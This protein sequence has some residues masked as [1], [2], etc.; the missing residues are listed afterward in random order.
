MKAALSSLLFLCFFSVLIGNLVYNQ[1]I[2]HIQPDGAKLNLLVSGD[3]YYHRVHD[4]KGY[5]ILQHPETGYVVYAIPDGNS[6]K[7]SDYVV[8]QSDPVALGIHPNLMKNIEESDARYQ[9]QQQYI[10]SETRTPTTGLIHNIVIFL[11]FQDQ[12]E[13]L[14]SPDF[15]WYN[16]LFNSTDQASLKDYYLK[17]SSYE[18]NMPSYFYPQPYNGQYVVSFVLPYNRGYFSPYNE[19]TNP[20]GYADVNDETNRHLA[21][22]DD[23]CDFL[24]WNVPDGIDLDI[25]N[26]GMVDALTLIFR[27]APD[28]WSDFLWPAHVT[29]SYVVGLINTT[30]VNHYVKVIE[31]G[32]DP[33]TLCH[34]TGHMIGFPDLYHYSH[35]EKLP[36]SDWDIMASSEAMHH[37]TYTKW[38]YGGWFSEIPVITPTPTPTQ[39]TL[40]AI[41]QNPYSCYK[42]ESNYPGQFYMLEYRRQIG[43]YEIGVPGTGLIAYRVIDSYA[44]NDVIGNAQGPPDE[45]Y[46]YR[47]EGNISNDGYVGS[48]NFSSTAGRVEIH[49]QTDPQPWIFINPSAQMDGNLVITEIGPSGGN[50]ITFKVSS[51]IPSYWLWDG[52]HDNNWNN[53]ANWSKNTVP[54]YDKDVVIPAGTPFYPVITSGINCN[55]LV[56]KS[57]AS[58]F[59]DTGNLHVSY[60][61]QNFGSLFMNFPNG[62]LDAQ[63]I[64]FYSGSSAQIT[65]PTVEISVWGNLTFHLGSD[66][67]IQEG[68]IIFFGTTNSQLAVNCPT[69][70]KNLRLNK[71]SPYT[72]TCTSSIATTLTLYGNLDIFSGNNLIN[73]MPG[74]LAI[75]G[76]FSNFSSSFT[77]CGGSVR[78]EGNSAAILYSHNAVPITFAALQIAK[79]SGALVTLNASVTCTSNLNISGGGGLAVTNFNLSINADL[80][81]YGILQQTGM[82][83]ITVGGMV[84]WNSGATMSVTNS[85][86][87]LYVQGHMYFQSDSNINITNGSVVF[88][89]TTSSAI[90]VFETGKVFHLRNAKSTVMVNIGLAATSTHDFYI[91]GDLINQNDMV[92][93]NY[94]T[95]T[96]RLKGNFT[97][98]INSVFLFDA[99]TL[100]FEGT[101]NQSLINN[102]TLTSYFNNLNFAM[103]S[104]VNLTLML[105]NSTAINVW[106][107]I[108]INS[109]IFD[110]NYKNINIKGNW[111]NNAGVNAFLER[112]GAVIF[113][114][115]GNQ[116]IYNDNFGA[117]VMNKSSGELI[118]PANSIV[119]ADKYQRDNG[120]LR[121]DG[122]TF[123]AGKLLNPGIYGTI[124]VN[125]G[126]LDMRQDEFTRMDLNGNLYM[127]GGTFTINGGSNSDNSWGYGGGVVNLYM[128]GGVLD[129]LNQ[130][131]FISDQIGEISFSVSGGT[132]RTSR[133]YVCTMNDIDFSG[134]SLELYNPGEA[135]I[136]MHSTS[137]VYNLNI[138]KGSVRSVEE[139]DSD[140]PIIFKDSVPDLSKNER[141]GSVDALTHLTIN[142]VLTINSGVLNAGTFDITAVGGISVYGTLK[143]N[144]A[145]TILSGGDFYWFSGSLGDIT[146]GSISFASKWRFYEGCN[147]VLTNCPVTFIGLSGSVIRSSSTTASFGNLTLNGGG[148]ISPDHYIY[149]ADDSTQPL[150]VT[151]TLTINPGNYFYLVGKTL[152]VTG[153]IDLLTGSS[154]LSLSSDSILRIGGGSI[155]TVN[156][157]ATLE[158]IGSSGHPAT[159]THISGNYGLTIASGGNISAEYTIFEYMMTSGVIV[160]SGAVVNTAHSF[161]YCTFQNGLSGTNGRLLA[162]NTNQVLNI[163]GLNFPTV[164]GTNNWN[165][166]KTSNQGT[167]NC[168][169]YTGSFSGESY[170][171]DTYNRINWLGVIQCDLMASDISAGDEYFYVGEEI[172]IDGTVYNNSANPTYIPVRIDLYY[173]R[174]TAPTPGLIGDQWGYFN[175]LTAYGADIYDFEPTSSV[176]PGIWNIWIQVDALNEISETNESNNVMHIDDLVTWLALPVVQITTIAY[177]NQT[178]QVDLTWTYPFYPE[179]YAHIDA[180]NIYRSINP[181]GPFEFLTETLPDA[182]TYS[183][184]AGGA[185]YFY[186]VKAE[187]TWP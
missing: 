48:A 95:Q 21:L 67:N 173:N 74:T 162:I 180:F 164:T 140:N 184:P 73:N 118:F 101:Y 153:N 135:V 34:E 23:V 22:I 146:A 55:S 112:D 176:V 93:R 65:H 171:L 99:G 87:D 83:D 28:G 78:L 156:S 166:A 85:A 177:N 31:E 91:N 51:E 3:E 64:T 30:Y 161:H 130:S 52:S 100:S 29:W 72:V 114:G 186:Q 4:E 139:S 44:G 43:N 107:N 154:R 182:R 169:N 36:V 89:G 172:Q 111:Y 158:T 121:V 117:L 123:V 150:T 77:N 25:D 90:Y 59:I 54:T 98:G 96:I 35:D 145:G 109:G 136:Q 103:A 124:Y 2:E 82:G 185:K 68:T 1:P 174:T 10:T 53:P 41:D 178:G 104:G 46:V 131:I 119:F 102:S 163:Y 27:G 170:D 9:T 165:I 179:I 32:L 60:G 88:Y 81:S 142:G 70:I 160:N 144:E 57:G 47:P 61:F 187:N 6:I 175:P 16:N 129:F 127:T 148:M 38:R 84:I 5:T 128:T 168:Y 147:V 62:S 181:Y 50:T 116:Y 24:S 17:V 45:I 49:N 42:I 152:Q 37:L 143:K 125:S 71:T 76:N 126:L 151:G 149:I 159:I 66:I 18:L 120:T 39:Y 97:N 133:N 69:S 113:N 86:A 7:A 12:T 137:S 75:K 157:G 108:T 105:T 141:L 11:R 183:E 15:Y 19:I 92:F 40:T 58:L 155:L 63:D 94:S 115:T 122:G 33:G 14:I 13:Y 106:G 132:I 110:C 138:N 26:D 79:S 80:V 134:G 20:G 56:V 167:V 8:G